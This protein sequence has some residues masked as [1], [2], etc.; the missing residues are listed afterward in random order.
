[1]RVWILF[2]L[3]LLTFD[4]TAAAQAP[5]ASV[6]AG[7]AIA[8][9]QWSEI[10]PGLSVAEARTPTRVRLTMLRIDQK[11]FRLEPAAQEKPDGETAAEFCERAGAELAV[12]GGFFGERDWR[13]GLYPV[14]FLRIDGKA[15]GRNWK[16][17]GGYI[18]FNEEGLRIAP[19]APE[20]PKLPATILQ[21][22]P[23]MI[24]P[25]GR[26]AMNTN[27]PPARPRT[28]LCTFPGSDEILLLIVHGAGLTLYETAWLM[29][30]KAEGGVFGCDAALALDGGS[31]TQLHVAGRPELTV[32]G[33]TAVHNA[34]LALRR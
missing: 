4:A 17:A 33:E 29:R 10:E 5:A 26:W 23:L 34:L 27:Q 15:S 22:K 32:E 30:S 28:A 2:A 6:E 20:P 24:A 16:D 12:N 13:K 7:L 14:G 1:M 21:S 3:I 25:G 11:R 8:D 19:A 31:S 9:S 18:L